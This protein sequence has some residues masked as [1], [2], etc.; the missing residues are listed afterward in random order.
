M[1]LNLKK[2]GGAVFDRW[3]KAADE[4]SIARLHSIQLMLNKVNTRVSKDEN[5]IKD[6]LVVYNAQH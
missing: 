3:I 5:S 6:K 4:G 2:D 1:L